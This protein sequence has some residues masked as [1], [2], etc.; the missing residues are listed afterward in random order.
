MPCRGGGRAVRARSRRGCKPMGRKRSPFNRPL[1]LCA[2]N[3]CAARRCGPV[4]AAGAVACKRAFKTKNASSWFFEWTP[5]HQLA[6]MPSSDDVGTE[7]A[8]MK[9]IRTKKKQLGGKAVIGKKTFHEKVHSGF[10]R[11]GKASLCGNR[12]TGLQESIAIR[13]CTTLCR[14]RQT[15]GCPLRKP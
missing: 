10:G 8:G 14:L 2:N 5:S 6:M 4:V 11:C 9:C 13:E 12:E 1:C 3:T 7:K 15:P